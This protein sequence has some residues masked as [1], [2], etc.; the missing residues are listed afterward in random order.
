MQVKIC[1]ITNLVDALFSV[2]AGAD[3]LGFV[4]YS[5][6]PRNIQPDLAKKIIEQLP[7]FVTTVGV[8]VDA[9]ADTVRAILEECGLSMVQLHGSELPEQVSLFS[10]LAIKAIR[11]RGTSDLQYLP[12]Y[13]VRAYLLDTYIEGVPGGTGKTFNWNLA[14]RAKAY[15]KVILAGGLTPE[16]VR[17]AVRTAEPDAVDVSSGVEEKPGKKS[18]EKIRRFV[19]EAKRVDDDAT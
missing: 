18:L 2:E 11:V 6:S 12:R 5:G 17:S 13:P 4:F 10:K 15:G 1:G 14:R 7:P 3:A 9:P 16:N 19:L 8:F